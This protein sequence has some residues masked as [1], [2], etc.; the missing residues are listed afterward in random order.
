MWATFFIAAVSFCNAQR[1]LDGVFIKI[2]EYSV[3]AFTIKS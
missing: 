2:I 3:N 1:F